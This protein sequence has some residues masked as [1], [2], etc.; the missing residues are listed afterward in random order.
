MGAV[1][2]PTVVKVSPGVVGPDGEGAR[3]QHREPVHDVGTQR[4]ICRGRL[5]F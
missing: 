4:S 3:V 1:D 5:Q 2:R